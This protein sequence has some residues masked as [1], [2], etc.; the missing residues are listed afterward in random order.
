MR[1]K[2]IA[3]IGPV[4]VGKSTVIK[5]L[6]YLFRKNRLKVKSIY[7]KAFHG[8]SYLLWKVTEYMLASNWRSGR[9]APWYIVGKVNLR[10]AQILLILS[11]FLDSIMIPLMLMLRVML[12]KLCRINVIVEEYLPGTL[13]EYV[14]SFYK[15]KMMT[16]LRN[17]LPFRVLMSLCL[18]YKPDF[19]ILLDADLY[20]IE[21]HWRIR[22]YGDPQMEYVIF[23]RQFLPKLAQ[24]FCKDHIVRL[25]VTSR[26][27]VSVTK[28]LY[29]HLNAVMSRV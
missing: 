20:E 25:D 11:L 13:L 12:P 17:S 7:I 6:L 8:P 24:T 22:G 5:T 26:S 29:K 15:S 10:V 19:T 14:Y 1:A 3:V 21:R 2:V 18:K 4:G 16:H 28:D 27:V 9:L 23:Q